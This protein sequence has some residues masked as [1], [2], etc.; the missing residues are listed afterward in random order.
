M[1]KIGVIGTGG[2][3]KNHLRVLD[4]LGSL[5]AF[6]DVD[7]ARRELYSKKYG[8]RGYES[9]EEMISEAKVDGVNVCTPASTHFAIASK[10]LDGVIA[11][12]NR[13]AERLFGYSAEGAPEPG[14]APVLGTL[15]GAVCELREAELAQGRRDRT[16]QE[17]R[18]RSVPR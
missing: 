18:S 15:A 13:G 17:R 10:T 2:W 9:F 16:A 3:G 7:A 4:E 12:W 14:V 5:A 11:S 8:V 1:V 6:A